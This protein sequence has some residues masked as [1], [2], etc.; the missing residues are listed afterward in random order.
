MIITPE[1]PAVL[2]ISYSIRWIVDKH[3]AYDVAGVSAD[4][5]GSVTPYEQRVVNNNG[6]LSTGRDVLAD[7]LVG[8]AGA[9]PFDTTRARVHV[10]D[11]T[12]PF[13]AADT[14]LRAVGDYNDTV[15]TPHKWYK[16]MDTSAYPQ[17]TNGVLKFRSR[18]LSP[19]ANFQWNE[20][21]VGNGVVLFNRKVASPS[22][23]L[24]TSEDE[25]VFSVELSFS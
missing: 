13:S 16:G 8:K 10:G 17:Y 3:R 11:S 6:L 2:P 24:K 5:I 7:L 25:W 21:G 18:F 4:E 14:D 19:E 15:G 23:G 12:S 20:F 22:V 1:Q 9:V